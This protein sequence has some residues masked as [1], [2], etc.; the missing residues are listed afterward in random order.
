MLKVSRPF[1]WFP[2]L[3]GGFAETAAPWHCFTAMLPVEY[4]AHTHADF[5]GWTARRGVPTKNDAGPALFKYTRTDVS[6]AGDASFSKD[7]AIISKE[8]HVSVPHSKTRF[9][10]FYHP[11]ERLNFLL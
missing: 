1:V 7:N 4:L 10:I 3:L 8:T 5:H 6:F 9:N 11:P 2:P